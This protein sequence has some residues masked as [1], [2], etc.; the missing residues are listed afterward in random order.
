M[1]FFIVAYFCTFISCLNPLSIIALETISQDRAN[2][3]ILPSSRMTCVDIRYDVGKG[4]FLSFS[5]CLPASMSA[6]LLILPDVAT[7]TV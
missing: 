6:S 3:I 7:K 2:K 4:R 5:I 1:S